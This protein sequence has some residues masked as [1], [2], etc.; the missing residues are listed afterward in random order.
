[1][2]KNACLI[3][4][5]H[6]TISACTNMVFL[7]FRTNSYLQTDRQFPGKCMTT[8]V[9]NWEFYRNYIF[10]RSNVW[11]IIK[12]WAFCL[13]PMRISIP[14]GSFCIPAWNSKHP[15]VILLSIKIKISPRSNL[16]YIKCY[17]LCCYE[18]FFTPISHIRLDA[19][20]TT[21]IIIF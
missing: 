5:C 19:W 12:I 9:L 8:F 10:Y 11:F 18:V 17:L 20:R 13:Y 3:T 2:L 7:Q 4:M 16:F 14:S 1:M 21:V 15:A 6:I